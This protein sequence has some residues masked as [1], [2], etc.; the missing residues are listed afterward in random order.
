MCVK[1]RTWKEYEQDRHYS[2]MKYFD[3]KEYEGSIT[4]ARSV[5]T[6]LEDWLDIHPFPKNKDTAKF[7]KNEK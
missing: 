3:G 5:I 4:Q 6:V 1:M 2:H 7:I